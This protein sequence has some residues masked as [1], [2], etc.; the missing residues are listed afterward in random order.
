MR[1]RKPSEA[2]FAAGDVVLDPGGAWPTVP[3]VVVEIQGRGLVVVW[4]HGGRG[5]GPGLLRCLVH[6]EPRANVPVTPG[7]LGNRGW[8]RE[9]AVKAALRRAGIAVDD[10][11][12]GAVG[13]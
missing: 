10:A 11:G 8:N 6:R 4:A 13:R 12:R 9:Q 7:M 5:G 3:A 1:A 2:P